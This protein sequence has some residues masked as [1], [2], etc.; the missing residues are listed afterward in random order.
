MGTHLARYQLC[1]MHDGI[2]LPC[3]LIHCACRELSDFIWCLTLRNRQRLPYHRFK[4]GDTVL[5][6]PSRPKRAN[7]AS[8][9]RAS[10]GSSTIDVNSYSDGSDVTSGPQVLDATLEGTVQAVGQ[11]EVR[12][13]V[14]KP[15]AETMGAAPAGA[16]C[17]CATS[18]SNSRWT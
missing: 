4:R 2:T 5:L 11:D 3:L 8:S 7:A 18:P 14:A 17:S 10:S 16:L 1:Q 13:A 6:A 12:V 9:Q 15:V